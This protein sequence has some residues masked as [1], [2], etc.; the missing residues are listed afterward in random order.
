MSNFV[1][2]LNSGIAPCEVVSYHS[3][4]HYKTLYWSSWCYCVSLF[5]I[6][7]GCKIAGWQVEW[8]EGQWDFS[9]TTLKVCVFD[10]LVTSE[11]WNGLF[12]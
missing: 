9:R 7:V 5:K 4:V 8:T 3:N 2:N 6:S 10:T 1:T 11:T 12:S